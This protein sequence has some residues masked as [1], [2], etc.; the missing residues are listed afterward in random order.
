M[1]V[2]A[3]RECARVIDAHGA[4]PVRAL[5]VRTAELRGGTGVKRVEVGLYKLNALDPE[6]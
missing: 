3:D 2:W 5:T 4:N 1:Y 6:A